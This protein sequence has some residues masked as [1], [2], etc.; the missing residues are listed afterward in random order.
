MHKKIRFFFPLLFV[1]ILG[2]CRSEGDVKDNQPELKRVDVPD[3]FLVPPQAK[4]AVYGIGVAQSSNMS[5][6]RDIAASRA[7]SDIAKQISVSVETMLTD[8][9][10]E[11]GVGDN[12][13]SIEYI[14]SITKEVA[15]AELK[16][17]TTKEAYISEKGYIYILVEYPLNRFIEEQVAEV[18]ARNESAAFAE[19]KALQALD[20]LNE[21]IEE[22]PPQ[23]D[24]LESSQS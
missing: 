3:W 23:S 13:Q 5:R 2:A 11:A 24:G 6:A 22:N 19:F 10:Q 8:Y 15:S 21:E 20:R 4:D 17:A 16:G 18:F 12:K 1:L 9:F 14:E 7:R